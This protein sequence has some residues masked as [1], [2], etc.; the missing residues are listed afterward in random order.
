[1]LHGVT[2]I[3]KSI[4]Q[5]V[6]QGVAGIGNLTVIYELKE[7]RV[8]LRQV[9]FNSIWA[10]TNCMKYHIRLSNLDVTDI[11]NNGIVTI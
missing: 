10:K 9:N 5:L 4:K 2:G 11:L 8:K 6:L 1:M 7:T 3:G